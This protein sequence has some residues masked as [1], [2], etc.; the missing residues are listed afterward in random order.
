MSVERLAKEFW[1]INKPRTKY[2]ASDAVDITIFIDIY[3]FLD[4]K[5]L[6]KK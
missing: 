2:D 5:D 6:I 3:R 1:A 4:E